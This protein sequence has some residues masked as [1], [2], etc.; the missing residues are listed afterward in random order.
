MSAYL[1]LGLITE[2]FL[3]ISNFLRLGAFLDSEKWVEDLRATMRGWREEGVGSLG[4]GVTLT[5]FLW[6]LNYSFLTY[7]ILLRKLEWL[8]YKLSSH[9]FTNPN[10]LWIRCILI[11]KVC[12]FSSFARLLNSDLFFTLWHLRI[13]IMRARCSFW[14]WHGVLYDWAKEPTFLTRLISV[15][16]LLLLSA[17]G[18]RFTGGNCGEVHFFRFS[19]LFD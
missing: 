13:L 12:E 6:P 17:N 1:L 16:V 18:C 14:G 5:D 19:W 15:I 3:N 4:R 11:F 7:S 2:R 8:R 10:S 9:C